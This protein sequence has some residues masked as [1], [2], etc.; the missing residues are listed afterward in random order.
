MLEKLAPSA[1]RSGCGGCETR[2]SRDGALC[3]LLGRRRRLRRI[4][5]TN[6]EQLARILGVTLA[7]FRQSASAQL[8]VKGARYTTTSLS[9]RHA[10]QFLRLARTWRGEESLICLRWHTPVRKWCQWLADYGPLASRYVE[11]GCRMRVASARS[12]MCA[13]C[14]R[15]GGELN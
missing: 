12:T 9:E 11:D 8:F 14:W 15:T 2:T 6:V 5:G 1:S 10:E 4:A 7:A 3:G 13:E